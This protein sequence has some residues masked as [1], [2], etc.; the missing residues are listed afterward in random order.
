MVC[1][2]Y[3]SLSQLVVEPLKALVYSLESQLRS[4]NVNVEALLTDEEA[5]ADGSM[6]AS[7]RLRLLCLATGSRDP[8][9]LLATAKLVEGC[10]TEISQLVENNLLSLV[11]IDEF[12]YIEKSTATFQ[13]CYDHIV[14]DLKQ[15]TKHNSRSKAAIPFLYLSATASEGLIKEILQEAATPVTGRQENA[16]RS[17]VCVGEEI[18][19]ISHVYSGKSVGPMAMVSARTGF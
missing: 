17:V 5:K 14:R 15:E 6:K 1:F 11:V 16:C 18:I 12:D 9:I 8:L 10:R 2:C 13:S 3:N 4:K 19:P 7:D